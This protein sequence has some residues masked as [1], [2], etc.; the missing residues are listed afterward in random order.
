[1]LDVTVA[2][3]QL[4]D[5]LA[6]L[7]LVGGLEERQRLGLG[8]H[9]AD[10]I[11][12]NPAQEDLVARGRVGLEL[13]RRELFTD[14]FVD[15]GG[16]FLDVDLDRDRASPGRPWLRATASTPFSTFGSLAANML[17]A[18]ARAAIKARAV[19]GL[20]FRWWVGIISGI[21]C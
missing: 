11:Q 12:I 4:V 16:A 3:E 19:V 6:A 2:L 15:P 7:S 21:G 17:P 20:G 14:Q 9:P 8:R 10:H 13:F 18:S 1:M 5:Q